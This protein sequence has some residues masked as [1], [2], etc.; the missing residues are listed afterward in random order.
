MQPTPNEGMAVSAVLVDR[1]TELADLR[2]LLEAR[3]A[4][5]VMRGRRRVGKSYLLSIAFGHDR[6][7]SFQADEQDE[8]GHLALFA[9]EAARLLPGAPPLAF[10]S[11]DEAFRFV[12]GQAGAEPLCLVL[13]EFQWLCRAQPALPSIVQ[14]HWDQWVRDERPIVVALAGSALSF[15]GGLLDEGSPLY[16]RATY[17]PTLDPL[18]FRQAAGFTS[19]IDPELLLRRYGIVGGT[20]QYQ[21]WA[22]DESLTH[23]L[24]ERILARGRPLY[25]D[26]LHL[27]RAGERIRSPGTYLSILWSIARGDSRFNAIANRTGLHGPNLSERLERLQELAYVEFVTPSDPKDHSRRGVYR[28]SDPYFRFWFRY[29]FPNRSRLELGRAEEV[30]SEIEADLDNHMG[31]IFEECCRLWLGRYAPASL[32]GS[33]DHVGSWWSRDG[34]VEVDV[35]THRHGRYTLLGSVKWSKTMDARDL[36]ELE[37]ARDQ[38]GP[39]AA[40]ARLMLC[41]R[42][43]FTAQ[44]RDRADRDGVTLFTARDLFER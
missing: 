15:M 2:A 5:V 43:G 6:V 16:G 32:T 13:D 35:A 21:V 25:D 12:D 34:Q 22:G 26:P 9:Q 42:R 17:R 1:E 37:E 8:H 41:A 18:D 40:G 7:L 19:R 10:A 20:P 11:W 29:V 39:R 38:M 31:P 14:R 4:L 27:L 30:A 33:V 36:D 23:T 28:I 24:S 44:L 3:P